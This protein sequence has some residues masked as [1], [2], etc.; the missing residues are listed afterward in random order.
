MSKI[1]L[2]NVGTHGSCVCSSGND[3]V[4]EQADKQV[5]KFIGYWSG[6]TS[7]ASLHTNKVKTR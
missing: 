4:C 3:C 1:T 2:Q 6:R 5:N 7:R